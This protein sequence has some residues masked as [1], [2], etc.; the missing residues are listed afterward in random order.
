[1][2]TIILL[3]SIGLTFSACGNSDTTIDASSET[4]SIASSSEISSEASSQADVESNLEVSSNSTSKP[5]SSKSSGGKTPTT[6]NPS[7]KSSSTLVSSAPT[8]VKITIPEGYTAARI[9]ETLEA[10]G[11]AKKDDLFHAMQNSNFSDYSLI[12]ALPSSAE[13]CF[14]LEGYLYPNTYE[15]YVGD[16]PENIIKKFLKTSEN[17]ITQECRNAASSLGYSM[18]DMIILASILEKEVHNSSELANVSSVFHNRLKAGQRLQSDAT[19]KYVEGAIKPYITGDINRY[20]SF[21]NTYKCKALPAGA[22]CNPGKNAIEGALYPAQTDYMYFAN[23]KAGN[24]Y[25]AATYEEH[26]AN[27]ET[28]KANNG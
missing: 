20:N 5:S 18:D 12:A 15:F 1:M 21:Y 2:I 28:I 25:Y 16:S 11:V 3:L 10:K 9:F 6:S 7:S 19:I 27:L 14:N 8:T 23:D 13:R 17:R 24:Y 4:S 22:I 26:L